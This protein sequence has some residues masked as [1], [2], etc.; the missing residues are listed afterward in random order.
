VFFLRGKVLLWK[1]FLITLLYERVSIES[2][3]APE[4]WI[5]SMLRKEAREERGSHTKKP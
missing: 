1:F 2:L 4:S 3:V 5:S